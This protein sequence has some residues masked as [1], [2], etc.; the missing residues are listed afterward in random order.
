MLELQLK[1]GF[2]ILKLAAAAEDRT[3]TMTRLNLLLR[4]VQ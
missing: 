2:K 4:K 3:K 1:K